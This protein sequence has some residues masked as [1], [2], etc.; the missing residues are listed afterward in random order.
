LD[1]NDAYNMFK[2]QHGAALNKT[3]LGYANPLKEVKGKCSSM[4]RQLNEITKTIEAE[5]RVLQRKR[6]QRM[7]EMEGVEGGEDIVDEEEFTIMMKVKKCKKSYKALHQ[8]F[9]AHT[10]KKKELLKQ[11]QEAKLQLVESFNEWYNSS[12]PSANAQQPEDDEGDV[13][14]DGE[15]FDQLEI[16]KVMEQDP[17]SLAFFQAQK[18]MRSTANHD[19]TSN[20]RKQK[21]KRNQ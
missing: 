13:L 12:R 17:D 6:E 2:R 1:R 16:T 5:D 20:M 8:E 21:L 18:K 4:A 9:K 14:D 11:A 15:Q 3:L 19:R 7:R 10:A